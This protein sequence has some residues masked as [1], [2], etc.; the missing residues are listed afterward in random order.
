MTHIFSKN[1]GETPF[2]VET[3]ARTVPQ[4]IRERGGGESP[5]REKGVTEVVLRG[6]TTAKRVSQGKKSSPWLWHE[7][8]IAL[9]VVC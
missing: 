2:E 9:L 3:L 7:Q 4:S 1:D 8:S 5:S 6:T